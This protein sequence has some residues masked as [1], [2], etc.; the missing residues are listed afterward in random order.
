MQEKND[1]IRPFPVEG[2]R[3]RLRPVVPDD[4]A[5]IHALRTDPRYNMH[6]SPVTGGVEDQRRW[7]ACY[8][9]REAQGSEIYFVIERRSD[10]QRCGVVRLYDITGQQFTWGSWILDEH[11][12][13]KAALESAVLI[14]QI[15]FEHM[16]MQKAV[17]DV[18]CENAHTISFH[19]R[20]GATETGFDEINIYFEYTCEQFFFHL[21]QYQRL[22]GERIQ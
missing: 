9:E 20:F 1:V 3:L 12:P 22:L 5:Y 6:L 19:R 14:Y 8:L 2:P 4:A 7:I 18:R 21:P 16:Q 17:F 10:A 15:G 13:S 11:K